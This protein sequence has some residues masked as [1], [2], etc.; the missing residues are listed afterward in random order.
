MRLLTLSFLLIAC[1]ENTG[2]P[3]VQD[4]SV[5]MLPDLAINL[6][7]TVPNA[8]DPTDPMSDGKACPMTGCP[9]GQVGVGAGAECKCWQVCDPATPQ[10]CPCD[11]RC[12]SL[13]RAD[14][15]VVG[16]ACLL[17]NGPGE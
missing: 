15:G 17:A 8:C 16:G 3:E 12:A 14:M 7:L 2:K 4:L 13:T 9:A 11:R 5:A 10:Q 6:D 1:G